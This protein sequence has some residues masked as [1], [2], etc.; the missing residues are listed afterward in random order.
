MKSIY[1]SADVPPFLDKIAMTLLEEGRTAYARYGLAGTPIVQYGSKIALFCWAGDRVLDTLLVQL[2]ERELPVERDGVAVVVN[3]ISAEALV[4]HLRALASQGPADAVQLAETVA[5]KLIEKH[6]VF[7]SDELLSIDYASCRLDTE[8]AWQA[9]LRA[10]A[11]VE[12]ER[13]RSGQGRDAP[14][15]STRNLFREKVGV[16]RGPWGSDDGVTVWHPPTPLST[17]LTPPGTSLKY[18]A[19]LHRALSAG[20]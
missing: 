14:E 9:A 4:P 12:V 8:G 19:H 1:E 18:A 7:M 15:P 3:D 20:T 11:Q 13:D 6:H 2:R 10:V 5:N 17:R 16:L